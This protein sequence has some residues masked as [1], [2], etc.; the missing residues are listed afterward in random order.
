VSQAP[1]RHNP[2]FQWGICRQLGEIAFDQLWDVRVRQQA[3]EF[4]GEL[5]RSGP[6][7]KPHFDVKR[8]ILSILVQ[9]TEL[10]DVSIK[11]RAGTLLLNLKK[12]DIAEF[13]GSHLL[14]RRLP[15]PTASLLLAKVQEI[16]KLDYDLH[17]L[18]LMRIA[19]YKQ[20]VYIDPMAKLSLQDTD[21]N[22][23]PLMDKVKDFIASDTKVMLVIGDSGAGKSTFNRYLE[24]E[25]WKEYNAGGQWNVKMLITCRTQYLGPDYQSRFEPHTMDR[26]NRV[27]DHRFQQAVIAPFT[28]EQIEDYVEHYV[29]LEKR[30]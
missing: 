6:D 25:L 9:I 22:L 23:F 1:F 7:W 17:M 27:A 8:W 20:A 15:L 5:Y 10:S 19:E 2:N 16:P 12:G 14:N 30:T 4:L 13:P 28:R 21:D 11:S 29:P 3:I 24:H 18:R 26:Y